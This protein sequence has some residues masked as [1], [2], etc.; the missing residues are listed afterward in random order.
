MLRTRALAIF[1]A[2]TVPFGIAAHLISEVAGLGWNAGAEAVVSPRHLY[3]TLIAAVALAGFAMALRG[4]APNYR[5]RAI[6]DLIA[7]LP[8]RGEGVR[9][10]ALSFAL[11]CGFFAAT[12]IGEGSPLAGGDVAVGVLAACIASLAGAPA[13]AFG[14]HRFVEIALA[15][16]WFVPRIAPRERAFHTPI[17]YRRAPRRRGAF[18]TSRASRPPPAPALI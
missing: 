17:A 4:V 10:T 3:L 8:F 5:R 9:F 11:Q 13:V 15:L 2:L 1:V 6:A 14:A 16:A 12:L 18:L 7:A